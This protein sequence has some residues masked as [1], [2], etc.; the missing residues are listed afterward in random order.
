M[1]EEA[2]RKVKEEETEEGIS[3]ETACGKRISKRISAEKHG[4][5]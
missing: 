5:K 1:F 4:K 3:R 2:M